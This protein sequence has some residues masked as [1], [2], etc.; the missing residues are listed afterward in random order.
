MGNWKY[1]RGQWTEIDNPWKDDEE[2][3]TFLRRDGYYSFP[4]VTYGDKR[5]PKLFLR[6]KQ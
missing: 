3:E 6:I 2:W 5:E 4:S 1:D